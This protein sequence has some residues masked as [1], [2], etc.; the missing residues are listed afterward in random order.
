MKLRL[1]NGYILHAYARNCH[2]Q[3]VALSVKPSIKSPC[4]NTSDSANTSAQSH[5]P[6][7]GC[8]F[9][10]L[11]TQPISCKW[12]EISDLLISNPSHLLLGISETWL[13]RSVTDA[14][15]SVKTRNIYR[16]DHEGRGG[17][18]LV[19]IPTSIRSWRRADL[20]SEKTE[21]VW[22]EIHLKKTRILLCNIS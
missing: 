12:E 18:I 22:V 1:V 14:A 13:D 10:H 6:P 11:N 9:A 19:Y 20:E 15:V 4:F 17:G 5:F 16:K 2:T 3:T 8:V 21:A 7:N